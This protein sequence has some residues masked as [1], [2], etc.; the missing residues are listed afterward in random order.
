MTIT[1]HHKLGEVESVI[2]FFRRET[3]R[4]RSLTK[5]IISP[6][7]TVIKDINRDTMEF[8]GLTFGDPAL[9]ALL[10]DLEVVYDLE[11]LKAAGAEGRTVEYPLSAR[12]PWA[13]ERVSG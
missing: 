13:W 1:L 11:V 12:Y 2:R 7:K 9:E 10:T 5:V 6:D 4:L 3:D 8:I